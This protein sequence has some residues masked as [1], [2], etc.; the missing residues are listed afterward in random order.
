MEGAQFCVSCGTPVGENSPKSNEVNAGQ[1]IKAALTGNTSKKV[2]KTV[3]IVIAVV[4]AVPI[5]LIILVWRGCSTWL[6]ESEAKTAQ[7]IDRLKTIE[8]EVNTAIQHKDYDTA[9]RKAEQLV[10]DTSATSSKDQEA[11]TKKQEELLQK[12]EQLQ[13]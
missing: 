1:K 9:R 2:F 3:K 7:E 6:K 5:V 12:L 13:D 10:W 8:I 4:I 11:W